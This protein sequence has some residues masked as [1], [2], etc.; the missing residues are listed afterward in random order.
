MAVLEHYLAIQ[1]IRFGDLV[2]RVCAGLCVPAGRNEN[3]PV[4]E[5]P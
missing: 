3:E 2:V 4:T 5:E 1:K